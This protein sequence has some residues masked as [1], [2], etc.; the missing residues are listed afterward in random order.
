M[1][2]DPAIRAEGLTKRYGDTLA[3][4][5]LS[6]V[7]PRGATWG[8][9]GGNGAGKSTTIA[10]LL[11]LLVPSAGRVT[12]LGHDMARD[13][14]AALARMNFSSPY[15]ALPHRLSVAENLRVYAHLYDVPRAGTRIAELAEAL[16][17]NEI[18]DRPAGQLSAGQKTRVA[19]AKALVNRPELLLL[20]EP[21]A[22]LDPDTGDWV[23]SW[24]ER[25]QAESGCAI[26]LAS[27]NMAEVE[28]LCGHVLMMKRGRIVDQ[29]SP[30]DLAAR[31]GRD[32]LE[33]VFLDI[34]RNRSAAGA[35]I[36]E[37][38]A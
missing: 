25:Y 21:T 33:D 37:S 13:R 4:D 29:G 2:P 28:R 19:L 35:K 32:N 6:F 9:L 16:Q 30:A 1:T 12:V 36:G 3:V 27:H 15:V 38:T 24:L 18:L 23:R 7:L 10:M 17:L 34:A 20:D 8:L 5:G 26:L 14:F 11:G 31:F 22:S